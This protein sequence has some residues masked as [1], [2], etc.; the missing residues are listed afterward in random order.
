M[1]ACIIL[2][3]DYF[4]SFLSFLLSSCLSFSCL[5]FLSPSLLL[6][7]CSL[8]LSLSLSLSISLSLSLSLSLSPSLSPSLLSL[9]LFLAPILH[10][11]FTLRGLTKVQA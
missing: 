2:L 4:H 6:S 10:T 9:S 3:V 8:S 5:L 11:F 1:V 7:S